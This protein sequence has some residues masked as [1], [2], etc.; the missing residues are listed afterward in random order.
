MKTTTGICVRAN[1]RILI[2]FL[3]AI[4]PLG[5]PFAND[6]IYKVEQGDNL[7]DLS[8]EYLNNMSHI[9]ELQ[10]LNDIDNPRQIPPGTLLRFPIKWLK[11]LPTDLKLVGVHGELSLMSAEGENKLTNKGTTI[12]AGDRLVT[13]SDSS[14]TIEFDDGSQIRLAP[15][16]VLKIDTLHTYG[17]SGANDTQIELP[18]GTIENNV[19]PRKNPS[20]RF[21]IISPSAVTGVRGTRYRVSSTND[22]TR[23][24]VVDGRVAVSSG[25]S[26]TDVNAGFATIA[27]RGQAPSEP[28]ALLPAP[29]LDQLPTEF[30]E[31]DIAIKLPKQSNSVA[32]RAQIF[33]SEQPYVAVFDRTFTEQ[34]NIENLPVGDYIL[35]CR[36]IDV[37]GIEG[38]SADH[39]FSVLVE[40]GW[41]WGLILFV[42]GTVLLL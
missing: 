13:G 18:Q 6:W 27:E 14:T 28:V 12:I 24:E 7:W 40:S 23:V 3:C 36:A 38:L 21:E 19:V 33:S 11:T 35:R 16:T 4:I 31:D 42:V 20:S 30:S 22:K 10:T 15:N 34:I 17:T 5:S 41:N 32:F 1:Y 9:E 8:E 29:K 26:S 37:N 25:S 39:Q 2:I